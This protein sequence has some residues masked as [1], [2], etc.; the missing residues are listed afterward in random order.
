MIALYWA[1]RL[2]MFLVR[3]TPRRWSLAAADWIGDGAYYV[4]A[5][6]RRVARDN[7]AHVLGKPP[8]DPAVS[9][10]VRGSFRNFVRLLR[11][12]MI[13]P[14]MPMEEIEARVTVHGGENVEQALR[15]GKGAIIVSAHFGNMDLASAVVAKR[16]APLTLVAETLRP[17]PLMDLLTRVRDA[18]QVRLFPYD[19][20]PRQILQ[21]LKRNEMTAFLLDFGV[22][23]HFD[24]ATVP[25]TFFGEETPFPAG[26]AQLAFLT[27]APIIVGYTRVAPDGHIDAYATPPLCVEHSGPRDRTIRD[28]MQ[29]IARR[30]EA[31]IRLSPEQWYIYRP[32]WGKE[33]HLKLQ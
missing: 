24:I 33:K 2:G 17:Q 8:D 19:R 27:G 11:D 23:H 3:I 1:W 9:R 13:Y 20:A 28:T 26:P 4:M 32:M 16:Y 22:T 15:L 21:A 5:L 12:V 14:S 29:E 7:L 10:V 31:F 18:H 30:M 6:R 25:V